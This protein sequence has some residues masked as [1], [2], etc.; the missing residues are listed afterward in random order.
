MYPFLNIFEIVEFTM[1]LSGTSAPAEHILSTKGSIWTAERGKLSLPV[2][3]ELLN[4]KADSN[5][6]CSKF[7]KK[8]KNYK[9]FQRKI[10][11]SEKY[12][13]KPWQEPIT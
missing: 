3:K 2:E 4:I 7:Y 10:L 9:P 6:S 8:I 5:M 12:E 1:C 13:A 11:L